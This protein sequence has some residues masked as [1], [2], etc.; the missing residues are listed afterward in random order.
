MS[1]YICRMSG[2][3]IL[4]AAIGACNGD[5]GTTREALHD[6]ATRI[7]GR[8][9]IEG[10]VWAANELPK[11]SMH[12]EAGQFI[13]SGTVCPPLPVSAGDRASVAFTAMGSLNATL[14]E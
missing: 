12:L 4:V 14:V 11:Y 10:L 3:L 2:L 9:P 5:G 7:M 1:G 8:D 13:V 6:H